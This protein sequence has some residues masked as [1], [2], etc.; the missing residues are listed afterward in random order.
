MG[1]EDRLA[2]GPPAPSR[3]TLGKLAALLDRQG[4]SV[5]EIGKIQRVSVYQS[6][7]K[8]EDG[9]AEIHDLLGVQF[10]RFTIATH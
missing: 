4:I 5:D 9:E 8:N 7:T 6:L 3:E 2:D 10:L 1:L